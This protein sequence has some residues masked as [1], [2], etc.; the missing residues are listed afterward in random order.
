MEIRGDVFQG[1]WKDAARLRA[2]GE[3]LALATRIECPVVAIHGDCDPHPYE[4]VQQP[5]SSRLEDFRFIMLE[6]CGHKPWIERE[7]R[8]GFYEVLE[9]ELR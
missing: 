2:S 3:L 4:G 6:N 9:D 8:E 7:A 1:V 5:L